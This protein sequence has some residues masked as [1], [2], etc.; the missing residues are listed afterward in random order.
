MTLN[1]P[2]FLISL[3]FVYFNFLNEVKFFFS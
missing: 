3:L 2:A 1:N